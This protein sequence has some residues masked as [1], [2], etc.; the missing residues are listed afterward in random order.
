MNF[1]NF[2]NLKES[3]IPCFK[4]AFSHANMSGS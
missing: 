4:G 2:W 3:K 1:V